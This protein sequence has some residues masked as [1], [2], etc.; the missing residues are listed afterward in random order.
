LVSPLILY[1]INS[2]KCSQIFN[3][4]FRLIG[5]RFLESYSRHTCGFFISLFFVANRNFLDTDVALEHI[6]INFSPD[7]LFLL[8]F[9]LGFI[10]FGVALGID[11]ADF[12]Q[13][14]K[15]PKA[16]IAG[17]LS[18]FVL[19]PFLTF[20]LILIF[21]PHPAFALGMILVASCPGGN[22]SNFFSSI[23]G[24]N[25]SLSVSLTA[26]ATFISPLFTPFNF[27]FYSN[28]V[29]GT[30]D[31][32]NVFELSFI[33]ML[34]T[35]V[36]LLV[37]P[38]LLGLGFSKFLP[39]VT[40]VIEKPIRIISMLV[41]FGFILIG[42]MN[43]FDAFLDHI[44]LVFL[45]VLTHNGIALL[46]GFLTGKAFKLKPDLS[47][48]VI[49]ET[50]IQNSG[51]GL[52][53]IFNFFDGNGAMAMIAAWWGIWHIISGMGVAYFFKLKDRRITSHSPS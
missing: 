51:L 30:R 14:R 22:I 52:I 5:Y 12:H 46:G 7:S 39:K 8:N 10:M 9:C 17:V 4:C 53:I 42:L 45:L 20:I 37:I 48:T 29:E 47:R 13:L 11:A 41:L 6:Q 33:D 43:N 40:G 38:L 16:A 27:E 35:T 1:G 26:I 50:G 15:N 3:G 2:R 44:D 24:A 19:L 49:I 36:I 32:M 21:Q 25:L 18:Q 31:F 28:L 23:A 34:K